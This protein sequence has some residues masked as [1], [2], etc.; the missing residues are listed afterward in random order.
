VSYARRVQARSKNRYQELLSPADIQYY[1]S[2][3]SE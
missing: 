2:K 1:P 3:V